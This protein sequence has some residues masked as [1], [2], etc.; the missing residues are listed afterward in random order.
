MEWL[1]PGSVSVHLPLFPLAGG[2]VVGT[3]ILAPWLSVGRRWQRVL[4]WNILALA[5][6]GGL[7]IRWLNQP[8]SLVLVAASALI[9]LLIL[10][11]LAS[12]LSTRDAGKV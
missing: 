3:C 5:V 8:S 4:G 6:A 2:V 9:A 11:V 7:V 1:A 10:S 12:F